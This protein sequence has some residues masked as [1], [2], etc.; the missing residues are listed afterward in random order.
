MKNQVP[1]IGD[2]IS[3]SIEAV[4]L[5][6][7]GPDNNSDC[8]QDSYPPIPHSLASCGDTSKDFKRQ[9]WKCEM[10]FIDIPTI[11]RLWRNTD[12]L[13]RKLGYFRPPHTTPLGAMQCRIWGY[14][15]WQS[16]ELEAWA[17]NKNIKWQMTIQNH[18]SETH[19]IVTKT[20]SLTS[21]PEPNQILRVNS[22]FCH[23]YVRFHC[24]L[25]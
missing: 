20:S 11:W 14:F 18:Q 3:L 24:G 2:S 13:Y 16:P 4:R 5:F 25:Y 9:I 15:C 10:G 17:Q 7:R 12:G 1:W 19:N 8:I 6:K 22:S 21:A 23:G